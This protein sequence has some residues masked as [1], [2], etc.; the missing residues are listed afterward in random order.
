[1]TVENITKACGGEL[2]G[3]C[4][5][6]VEINAVTT[7]S[8]QVK[9][10][11]IF[12]ALKGE[13]SDGHDYIGSAFEKGALC[14]VSEKRLE[15]PAGA[16]IL[17][18]S[19]YRALERIAAFYR[20]QLTIPVIGITG[21]VGKTTAK[22]MIAAVLSARYRVLKTEKNNNNNLG[23]PLTL[24]NIMPEHEAAVV[25]MGISHFG[26]MDD[27]AEIAKPDMAVFTLI[28]DSHLEYLGDRPGVLRAKGEMLKHMKPGSPLFINGDDELLKKLDCAQRKISFGLGED[29]D[30]RAENVRKLS[31]DA[32][33]CTIV[34]GERR[35]DVEIPAF[36][37]HMVYA[38][39]EGAA[40][41][42]ELGLSDGEIAAGIA[43]YETV[44]LRMKVERTDSLTI[45]NDCYNS[46]PNSA[47]SALMSLSTL[48]GRR[49]CIL[50]DML[51]LGENS[52]ELH[53]E[54]GREAARLGTEYIIACGELSREIY[55]GA[56]EKGASDRAFYFPDKDA[57][58][59]KLP[60]LLRKDD[61][62]LVKA[63]HGMHFEILSDALRTMEL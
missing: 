51:E 62:V 32:M 2:V 63:S 22:E 56:C 27:M 26:E 1:M 33:G 57:L 17:V 39:L 4:D 38:A 12:I 9:P 49:V 45:L 8:R 31:S 18:E 5:A 61:A 55:N 52:P 21:S 48:S 58:L 23:V 42:I 3:V 16:Y 40:V 13:N 46:N 50:G 6:G 30:C 35:F 53:R 43:A 47:K 37:A 11:S 41:G 10:G 60:S 19:T 15:N 34:S 14:C 29:C 59:E 54:L 24:L 25:E 36:G 44:G 7:D 28:G 20:S